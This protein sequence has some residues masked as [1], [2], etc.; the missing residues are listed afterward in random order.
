MRI[1]VNK[2][3][4]KIG[5]IIFLA[6]ISVVLLS[7]LVWSVCFNKKPADRSNSTVSVNEK[8]NSSSGSTTQGGAID[9]NGQS[10]VSNPQK[11][12]AISSSGSITLKQPINN[13]KLNTGDEISGSAKVSKVQYRIVDDAIGVI[14]QGELNVVSGEFAGSLQF[15]PKGTS[16]S[17]VV[18]SFDEQSREINEIEISVR[19]E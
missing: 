6:T 5:F 7:V 17:L 15:H 16:G 2:H 1:Q 14:S 8:Q 3:H 12:W 4:I 9:K 11:Q 18:F 10:S 13:M 19:F